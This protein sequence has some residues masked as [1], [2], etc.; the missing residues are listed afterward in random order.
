[1][2]GECRASLHDDETVRVLVTMPG[3]A[4]AVNP[5]T[6]ALS[7]I[8]HMDPREVRE[9]HETLTAFLAGED[10]DTAAWRLSRAAAA[11]PDA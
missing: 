2:R 1:M 10:D 8:V 6:D 5:R 9:L 11:E 7:V 4:L 3:R